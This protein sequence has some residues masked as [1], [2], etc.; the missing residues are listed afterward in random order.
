M[1]DMETSSNNNLRNH[2]Q[3]QY[4]GAVPLPLPPKS[5]TFSELAHE[6]NSELGLIMSSEPKRRHHQ[7][8]YS[9]S[10]V[11]DQE[12]V[13]SWLKELLDDEPAEAEADTPLCSRRS[14]RR[15]SS[16]SISIAYLQLQKTAE[17]RK[18]Y[19]TTGTSSSSTSN[20]TT[21]S[22]SPPTSTY[23]TV[24]PQEADHHH[25]HHH[26][27]QISDMFDSEQINNVPDPFR[28]CLHSNPASATRTDSKR[29]KRYL[30]Y[31]LSFLIYVSTPIGLYLLSIYKLLK[32]LYFPVYR[33]FCFIVG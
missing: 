9:D 20:S 10:L 30:Y 14:H 8:T 31:L 11:T 18:E 29:V 22:V 2:S 12:V 33:T 7:R 4:T 3:L 26:A 32:S 17:I 6:C 21:P 5:S 24:T 13:P 23:V 25:H 27:T 16:D 15:S 28:R 19:Q 1:Q